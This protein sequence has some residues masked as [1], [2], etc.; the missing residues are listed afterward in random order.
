[1]YTQ[2]THVHTA[3]CSYNTQHPR[4][5]SKI[6]TAWHGNAILEF[7]N[8]TTWPMQL[9]MRNLSVYLLLESVYI[10]SFILKWQFVLP[11]N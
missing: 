7:A 6:I 1:M 9:A 10:T 5:W 11:G 4:L 3:T 2:I 8:H